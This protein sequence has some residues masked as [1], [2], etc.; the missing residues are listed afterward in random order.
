MKRLKSN[1]KGFTLIE[2]LL[3]MLITSI[4][5]LGINAAY[6]QAHLIW[7]RAEESRPIYHDARI[8]T[9]VLRKELSGIYFS[10]LNEEEE[11]KDKKIYFQLSEKEL[12]FYTTTP[13]WRGGLESSRGAKVSYLLN[14][15]KLERSEWLYS[16]E[17]KISEITVVDR[18]AEGLSQL[19]FEVYN[20]K[21]KSDSNPWK[22]KYD[23][24]NG[25]PKVVRISLGWNETKN[26][27]KTYFTTNIL[28]PCEDY[29]IKE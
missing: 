28:I 18:V 11:D 10:P 19:K 17:K 8:I 26:L 22:S 15:G 14:E 23:P 2:I 3:V 4:L 7:A 21:S 16:G 5:V 24:E 12:C 6:K 27:P 13:S 9:E 29:L 20:P 25:L 1:K